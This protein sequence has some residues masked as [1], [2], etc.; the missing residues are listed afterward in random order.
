MYTSQDNILFG[1][2]FDKAFYQKVLEACALTQ[3]IRIL[4][5]GDETE[6][7]EKGIN[8]SGGQKQR[9]S[10]ARAVYSQAEIY[11]LDD[12]LSA[13]DSHVGKHIFENVIGPKGILANKTRLLVT[14]GISY[15][16]SVDNIFVMDGGEI[17]ESGH[18]E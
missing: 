18:Y 14:H 7:G 4:P 9:V 17:S 13:V 2:Q 15:L 3:D 5:G 11:L 16:P 12:P 6:I 8:L 10:L 1:R